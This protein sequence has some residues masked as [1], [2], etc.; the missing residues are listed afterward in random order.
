MDA[1]R[2]AWLAARKLGIGSSD[3]AAVWGESPYK[4]ELQLYEEKISIEISE[5]SSFI[6]DKGNEYEPIA[7]GLFAAEYNI[8]HGEDEKFEAKSLIMEEL[9]YMRASLDGYS[10]HCALEIKF[11]GLEAHRATEAGLIPHHY[12]IQMQHQLLVA[13]LPYCWFLS[14]NREDPEKKLRKFRVV[15]DEKF[16]VEHVNRCSTFWKRVTD[17]NPPAPSKKD[18]VAL[19]V[20]G[21]TDKVRR[22]KELKAQIAQLEKEQESIREEII[23]AVTHPRMR[24]AD[25]RI[26]KVEKK[27]SVKWDSI[28]EV[29]SLKPDYVEKFRGKP[30]SYYKL[31]LEIEE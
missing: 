17:K 3:A 2:Q 10:K 14:Y 22:W 30:S 21:M 24:C 29:K 8:E 20:K 19:K 4:T 11:Q 25:L 12:Y 18:Y 13:D 23:G 5:E 15:R 1:E 16:M 9:P 7:R 6:M 27:G 31:D 28:P 26:L